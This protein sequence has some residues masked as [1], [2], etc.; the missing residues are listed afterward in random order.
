MSAERAN[1]ALRDLMNRQ[2]KVPVISGTVKAV[3]GYT[4]DV[5]PSDGGALHYDVRLKVALTNADIGMYAI[6]KVGS[7]VLMAMLDNQPHNLVVIQVETAT[8]YVVRLDGGAE[9]EM[10]GDGTLSLN[11]TQHGG[12]VKVQALR[13]DLN[14]LNSLLTAMNQAFVQ[15]AP[16]DGAE[17]GLKAKMLQVFTTNPLPNYQQIESEHTRHG[18]I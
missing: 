17:I 10:K 1:R 3:S 16:T 9:V 11:G 8:K 6:P 2:A 12:L 14:A 5:E 13:S 18:S 15:W 7:R 4:C